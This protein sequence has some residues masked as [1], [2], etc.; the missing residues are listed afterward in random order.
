M[1]ETKF[2]YGTYTQDECS[3]PSVEAGYELRGDLGKIED[4]RGPVMFY[5]ETVWDQIEAGKVSNKI[6]EDEAKDAWFIAIFRALEE[7]HVNNDHFALRQAEEGIAIA[8]E[9]EWI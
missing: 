6:P 4:A 1:S 3:C 9:L 7:Y 2:A 8:K 5:D